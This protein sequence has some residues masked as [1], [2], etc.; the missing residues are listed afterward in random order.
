MTHISLKEAEGHDIIVTPLF[1]LEIVGPERRRSVVGDAP[2]PSFFLELLIQC[3]HT[4]SQ[5]LRAGHR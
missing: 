2:L 4:L 5:N 3:V 1:L